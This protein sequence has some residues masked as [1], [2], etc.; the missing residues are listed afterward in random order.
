MLR[1]G[2]TGDL[3]SGKSTVAR[4]LAER[5]AVLFSSDEMGRALMEPGH[6]VFDQIVA[7]FGPDIL[8]PDGR[9]DRRKLA[10]AA[11]APDHPRIDELNALIHPAVIA[12]Q[13]RQLTRLRAEREHAIAVVESA[14]IFSAKS[15]LGEHWDN[16]FDVILMVTAPEHDKITRYIER[17]TEGRQISLEER[18]MLEADA[19]ARLA[20]QSANAEHE[21]ECLV[22]QNRGS[23]QEL[24]LQVNAAWEL[25]LAREQ[26][27]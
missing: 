17:V 9:L 8:A 20:R 22:L 27:S 25:L 13:Q 1:V 6:T 21:H 23:M 5:G 2:L 19:R 15:H 4:M 7:A 14:L 11:F 16:R 24:A 12:E 10:A 18:S 26:A 3:G